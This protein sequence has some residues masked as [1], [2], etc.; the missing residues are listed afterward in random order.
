[1][2]PAVLA[3]TPTISV[4]ADPVRGA[5][6]AEISHLEIYYPGAQWERIARLRDQAEAVLREHVPN[7]DRITGA[8]TSSDSSYLL[9]F[10]TIGALRVASQESR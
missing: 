5:H 1:M 6:L 10:T 4:S 7:L 8:A 9:W 2:T 3:T